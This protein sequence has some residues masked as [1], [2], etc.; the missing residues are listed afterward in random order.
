MQSY[1]LEF[2][3][4]EKTKWGREESAVEGTVSRIKLEM[5]VERE[6]LIN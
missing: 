1:G 5:R 4:K 6:Q 2:L 3:L